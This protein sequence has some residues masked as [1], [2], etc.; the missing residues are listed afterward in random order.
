MTLINC[1][2]CNQK[3]LSVASVC[4]K[5]GF[6]FSEQ[7]KKDA[8]ST[9]AKLCKNCH[10]EIAPS[11]QLCPHCG[12]MGPVRQPTR[13]VLPVGMVIVL[14]VAVLMI[15]LIGGEAPDDS[16]EPASPEEHPPAQV[17][18]ATPTQPSP[19]QPDSVVVTQPI[20]Q[21]EATPPPVETTVATV[22][23]WTANW[24]NVRA[25]RDPDA[26]ILRVLTPGQ[27]VQVADLAQ[28][29][30][31]VYLEGEMIGFVARSLILD[32]PPGSE[33][34]TAVPAFRLP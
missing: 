22:T 23:R 15:T 12:E 5:C 21:P 10:R 18:A 17:E 32:Q 20:V 14:A 6:S 31:A 29:W 2:Q 9:K 13:W 16:V 11:A 25:D 24:V 34:D 27:E 26:E 1:P 8:H 3:V 33:P 19:V 28:G 7:R 4:P 30:W